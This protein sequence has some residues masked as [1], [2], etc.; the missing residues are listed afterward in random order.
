M[1]VKAFF[2]FDDRVLEPGWTYTN[3]GSNYGQAAYSRTGAGGAARVAG[4]TFAFNGV[5]GLAGMT[6]LYCGFGELFENN[7]GTNTS[8]FRLYEGSVVHLSMRFD[9]SGR[10]LL[11]RGEGTTLLATSAGTFDLTGAAWHYWEVKAIISDTVGVFEVRLDGAVFVTYSGDTRNAGTT[12]AIDQ[13]MWVRPYSGSGNNFI[14]DDFWLDDAGY[15]GDKVV[16][17]LPANG[18]GDSSQWV[19]SDGNSTDNYL[20]VDDGEVVS[21]TDYV[22]SATSGNTDLYN[23]A[24]LPA[25]VTTVDA[26]QE[27]IYVQASDGGTPPSVVPVAKGAL[28]TV[29][30]DTALGT[31]PVAAADMLAQIRTTDPDGN[32]LTPARVNAMQVGVKIA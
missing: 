6:T 19:G 9:T 32:A 2:G 26:I 30:A 27:L 17:S 11:Y 25:S 5:P 3:S 16:Y 24:D 31:I 22:A 21:I 14:V 12:G 29:R 28:G 15:L 23:I 4:L 20:L 13:I 7:P 18:N 10:L 1:A 8:W